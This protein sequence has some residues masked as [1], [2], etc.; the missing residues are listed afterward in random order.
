MS[1]P[2]DMTPA[3]QDLTPPPTEAVTPPPPPPAPVTPP[4]PPPVAYAAPMAAPVATFPDGKPMYDASGR[5]A[6]PK[7]RLAAAILAWFLGILGVHRFYV[8][9]VGT[10]ILMIVTLGGLGIWAL[11]DFIVIL[12]GSFKDKQGRVLSN[13]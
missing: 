2:D 6:S 8:G 9:K 13:W 3:P 7:S 5:P 10:G 4:P 12:V 1:T 11:I